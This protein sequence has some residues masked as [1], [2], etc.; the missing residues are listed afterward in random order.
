MSE[1]RQWTF[2]VGRGRHVYV[3]S[4]QAQPDAW[5]TLQSTVLQMVR[6]FTFWK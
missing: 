4:A 2:V 3:I 1:V 6:P 5:H